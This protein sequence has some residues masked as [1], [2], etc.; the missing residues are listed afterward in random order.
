[1]NTGL[2]GPLSEFCLD[3]NLHSPAPSAPDDW[4]TYVKGAESTPSEAGSDAEVPSCGQKRS[5]SFLDEG[6]H[7]W[8]ELPRFPCAS[9]RVSR[10]GWS[11]PRRV[12]PKYVF[13]KLDK[14]LRDSGC[15]EEL[16]K[17]P[18]DYEISGLYQLRPKNELD[19]VRGFC[20][21]RLNFFMLDDMLCAVDAE[22]PSTSA[23]TSAS[24]N[25]NLEPPSSNKNAG[26]HVQC[27]RALG[28]SFVYHDL[29]RKLGRHLSTDLGS[30]LNLCV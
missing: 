19:C 18:A 23:N 30:S 3:S 25:L 9:R 16:N 27:M 5:A 8:P 17:C 12:D 11:L 28:D 15:C 24:M 13:R 2:S 14:F 1:M 21:F 4:M 20:R 6:T 26:T 29:V 10:L 7:S 22:S